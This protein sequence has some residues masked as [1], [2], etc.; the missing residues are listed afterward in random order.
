MPILQTVRRSLR[1][2][3]MKMG[4]FLLSEYLYSK[5]FNAPQF[6]GSAKYM[7][8]IQGDIL[9]IRVEDTK[10]TWSLFYHITND[11]D[12]HTR[13]EFPLFGT[14]SQIYNFSIPL[15]EIPNIIK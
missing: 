12:D 9:K 5:E 4:G 14:T 8:D 6:I 1:W 2:T 15:K 13:D 10:N 3:V 11:R 7:F